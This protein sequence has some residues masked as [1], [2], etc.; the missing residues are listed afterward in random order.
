[1]HKKRT[2]MVKINVIMFSYSFPCSIFFSA[3]H[4]SLHELLTSDRLL[5]I[6]LYNSSNRVNTEFVIHFCSYR[7]M[8]T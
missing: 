2:K 8:H 3:V 5:D 4:S 6:T 1:M 7:H